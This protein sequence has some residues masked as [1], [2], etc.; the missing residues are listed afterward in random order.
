MLNDS[1][2]KL[3][4]NEKGI[5]LMGVVIVFLIVG[6]ISISTMVGSSGESFR[7]Q[8]TRLNLTTFSGQENSL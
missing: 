4:N 3:R 1:L 2:K 5:A 7:V 8:D 6:V